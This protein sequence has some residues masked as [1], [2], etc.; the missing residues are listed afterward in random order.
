MT[1]GG[2]LTAAAIITVVVGIGLIFLS[3][4]ID[5]HNNNRD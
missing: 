3:V 2:I 4:L 1:V 5:D